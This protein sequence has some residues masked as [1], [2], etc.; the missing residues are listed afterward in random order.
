MLGFSWLGDFLNLRSIKY[1]GIFS[2]AKLY[3]FVLVFIKLV[4]EHRRLWGMV[5]TSMEVR[6]DGLESA[7]G[8]VKQKTGNLDFNLEALKEYME[9]TKDFLSYRDGRDKTCSPIVGVGA[10]SIPVANSVGIG[11]PGGN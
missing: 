9:E 1:T 6:V 4:S 10:F 3:E 7:L 5:N 2:S 11:L 8:E